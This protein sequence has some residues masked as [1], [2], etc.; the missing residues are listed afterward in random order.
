MYSPSILCDFL[1]SA[2]SVSVG[3]ILSKDGFRRMSLAP[4]L[5]VTCDLQ[6]S[7]IC[8]TLYAFLANKKKD[9]EPESI[10]GKG[11]E[12]TGGPKK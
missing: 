12:P 10:Q 7:N 11:D 9:G 4:T 6:K 1:S 8:Q 5:C 2:T 3:A